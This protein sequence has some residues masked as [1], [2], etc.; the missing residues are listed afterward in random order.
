M[1]F[2]GSGG[3]TWSAL[4]DMSDL[5]TVDSGPNYTNWKNPDFFNG[6]KDIENAKTPE[7]ERNNTKQKKT[8]WKN[9]FF[10]YG[11]KYIENANSPKKKHTNNKHKKKKKNNNSPWLF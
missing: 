9:P 3:A 7:E 8:N 11:W 2:L 1:F 10:F 4:Y 6:W 5:A